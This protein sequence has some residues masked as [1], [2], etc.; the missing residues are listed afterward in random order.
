MATAAIFSKVSGEKTAPVG[1]LGELIMIA[2]VF[3]V[4]AAFKTSTSI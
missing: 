1:L 3:S 2:R 4:I